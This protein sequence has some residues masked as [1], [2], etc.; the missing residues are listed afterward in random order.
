MIFAHMP[1]SK[2]LDAHAI[3]MMNREMRLSGYSWMVFKSDQESSI[4]ELLEAV[5]RE[6][7]EVVELT[8]GAEEQERET[9][10][11]CR[12]VPGGGTLIEW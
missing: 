6:K 8:E 3:K 1:P 11:T 12:G 4:V 7:G 5:K 2:G 9:P 10:N